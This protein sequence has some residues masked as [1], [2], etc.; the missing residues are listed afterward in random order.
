MAGPTQ[1]SITDS[2]KTDIYLQGDMKITSG[3]DLALVSGLANV[4]QA[5]LHRLITVPGTLVHKP[6]YGIG[7]QS[8][9][10]DIASFANQQKLTQL[11]QDQFTQ[12]PRVQSVNSVSF[13]VDDIKPDLTKVVVIMTIAGY[14]EQQMSFT[15]FVGVG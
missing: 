13:Q 12:D 8:F 3:G 11:I 7:I 10:N 4:Q 15:P 14:T 9:Q 2:L 6:S 1:G 5:L